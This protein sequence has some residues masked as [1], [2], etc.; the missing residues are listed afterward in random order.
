MGRRTRSRNEKKNM[1]I[2]KY[3]NKRPRSIVLQP[4]RLFCRLSIAPFLVT[5]GKQLVSFI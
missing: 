5:T 2:R 4:E 3:A 1:N